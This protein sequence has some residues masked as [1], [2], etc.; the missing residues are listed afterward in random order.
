MK[1]LFLILI[2]IA[3]SA[4]GMA[5]E[6]LTLH[7]EVRDTTITVECVNVDAP[8]AG[9]GLRLYESAISEITRAEQRG[10]GTSLWTCMRSGHMPS[11]VSLGPDR[12]KA[13]ER[14]VSQMLAD[15]EGD[16]KAFEDCAPKL[17]SGVLDGGVAI[18]MTRYQERYL[19]IVLHPDSLRRSGCPLAEEVR[20]AM[21]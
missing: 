5:L 4:P 1:V 10:P 19:A 20:K 15:E 3:C 2:M 11:R 12:A 16:L 6:R 9:Y 8:P 17:G 7:V 18:V 13:I 14:R 21:R